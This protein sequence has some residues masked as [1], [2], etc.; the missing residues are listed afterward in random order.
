MRGEA[1]NNVDSQ[2]V[3]KTTVGALEKTMSN[4]DRSLSGGKPGELRAG[5]PEEIIPQ[6]SLFPQIPGYVDHHNPPVAF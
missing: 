1:Q 3:G 4:G 6:I 2:Q 5:R